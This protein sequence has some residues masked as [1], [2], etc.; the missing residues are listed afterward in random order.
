MSG[1]PQDVA[2]LEGGKQESGRGLLSSPPPGAQA[3]AGPATG[4]GG[5]WSWPHVGGASLG[6]APGS[7]SVWASSHPRWQSLL[8]SHGHLIPIP[9]QTPGQGG[10]GLQHP[11]A[12]GAAEAEDSPEVGWGAAWWRAKRWELARG[13]VPEPCLPTSLLCWAPQGSH[14]GQ[15]EAGHPCEPGVG[16]EGQR[17]PLGPRLQG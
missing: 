10:G 15:G 13:C 12:C 11:A 17:D 9:Q 6:V 16:G 14:G 8:A 4:V 5:E 1:E 2:P 7:A 3:S